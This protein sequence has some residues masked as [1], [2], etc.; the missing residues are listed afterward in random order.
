[1]TECLINAQCSKFQIEWWNIKHIFGFK[2]KFCLKKLKG[3]Y[4]AVVSS[5]KW[6]IHLQELSILLT[7][8]L[9]EPYQILMITYSVWIRTNS[10][11]SAFAN[12]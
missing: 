4:Q 3:P 6:H 5:V 9:E 2:K 8:V 7:K 10:V 11:Q 1:M 12:K